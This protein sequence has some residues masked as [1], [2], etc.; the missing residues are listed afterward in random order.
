M[1]RNSKKSVLVFLL[2][3][4][5]IVT[6][7]LPASA[8]TSI[9]E[10]STSDVVVLLDLSQSVLPYF[11]D[12]TDYVVSGVVRDFLRMGDTFHLLSFGDATQV[13]ISQRVAGE[14]EVRSI[15]ARLYLLYPLARNTDLVSAFSYLYQYLADLPE[16]RSKIVVI[17]TDG[18][19]NAAPGSPSAA[20]GPAET[21]QRL[22]DI[23]SRI[24]GKGWPVYIIK[25][26]FSTDRSAAEAR[27][28]GSA[29]PG[30]DKNVQGSAKATTGTA[31]S[32]GAEALLIGTV[33]DALGA[34]VTTYDPE[35]KG[36]LARKSLSLPA[37]TF[38][39]DLGKRGYA[40][41]FPL[42][43]HNE[44]E[45]PLAL[46]LDH[47]L[48]D[49]T[50]ILQKKSFLSLP[51]GRKA[52]MD[53]HIALPATTENGPKK[54]SLELYFADGIRV[55]PSHGV[56]SF[57]LA[58][59]PL[60]RLFKSGSRI[61]LFVIL[62]VA[63][64]VFVL[65][66]LLFIQKR[67]PRQTAIPVVR[68]VR[69]AAEEAQE[70]KRK[71]TAAGRL[72]GPGTAPARSPLRLQEEARSARIAPWNAEAARPEIGTSFGASKQG[73]IA[74]PGKAAEDHPYAAGPGASPLPAQRAADRAGI[75]ER[76]LAGTQIEGQIAPPPAYAPRVV[77]PGILQV[78]LRVE[79]QNPS[80]GLRNV[81]SVS[82][83]Y[84]KSVGGGR[85]DY[86]V[87]LL[88]VPPHVAELHYDGDNCVFVPRRMEFF[89]GLEGP[90]EDCL[91]KEIPMRSKRGHP[92][93]LRFHKYIAPKD[94]INRLLH[95]IE[96]P[97]LFI[98]AED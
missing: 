18:V 59:N 96:F 42:G 41:S 37:A 47:V 21:T 68:A 4:S 57:E 27:G 25:V 64:L 22:A 43:I 11:H 66:A 38:P 52:T 17:I 75:A 8:A 58:P 63:G 67:A 93:V 2:L 82:A 79:G 60:A 12:I 84:S 50:D 53:V 72:E 49:G 77:K 70:S 88:P 24:R 89:P 73:S 23:G 44:G 13:E 19:E 98:Q 40:F 97:G 78:E 6:F 1:F 65:V 85:S 86:L 95:C 29:P 9:E 34:N 28:S 48:S 31:S 20:L 10:T 80:I 26:P 74:I 15:L 35:A 76:K 83:G 39:G 62:M 30:S 81:Q 45:T 87:F 7:N 69:D 55:S 61:I 90:V 54:L 3:L 5:A 46:E 51:P 32:T 92:M 14:P 94:R 71:L 33:A 56:I 91:G 16:S 36:D